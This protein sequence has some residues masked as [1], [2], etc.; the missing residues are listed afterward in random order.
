MK[1][2]S[3]ILTVS[4]LGTVCITGGVVVQAF[5]TKPIGS[6]S[7]SGTQKASFNSL[8]PNGQDLQA[9]SSKQMLANKTQ[10][11][12]LEQQL[13]QINKNLNQ[14]MAAQGNQQDNISQAYELEDVITGAT[15]EEPI[16]DRQFVDHFASYLANEVGSVED[17]QESTSKIEQSLEAELE[18]RKITGVSL[19]STECKATLCKIELVFDNETTREIYT[20][21]GTSI[22]PWDGQ[23]FYHQSES[24]PNTM[25][26]YVAKEGYDLAMPEPSDS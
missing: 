24:E 19:L 7:E 14:L 13:T 12:Q 21:L 22:I 26:Y 16:E 1:K 25:I 10:I 6:D 3:L 9:Q 11:S 15:V 20:G 23:A 5:N 2:N 17:D 8:P 4:I 18:S